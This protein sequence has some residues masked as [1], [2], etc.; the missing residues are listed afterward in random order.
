MPACPAVNNS[1]MN[2]VIIN[3]PNL[4]MLGTR[5]PEIYGTTG[6]DD[7]LEKLRKKYPQHDIGYQLSN[8]EGE[9]I[10]MIQSHGFSTDG[11]ILNAGGY[12]HTSVAISD[13][14]AAIKVPVVEV[15]ISNIYAREEERRTSLLSRYCAGSITGLGLDGYELALIWFTRDRLIRMNE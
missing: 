2:I 1:Y 13:A 8:I 4:N 7:Y 3:G 6:F 12:T 9:I 14:V 15:H 5:Q 10:N 11:I